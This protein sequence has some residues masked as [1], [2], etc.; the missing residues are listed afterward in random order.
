MTVYEAKALFEKASDNAINYKDSTEVISIS[1]SF[2]IIKQIYDDFEAKDKFKKCNNCKHKDGE[3][4]GLTHCSYFEQFMPTE[5]G[6]CDI[7]E[8]KSAR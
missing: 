1:S 2:I 7:W 6:K 8:D 4:G 5:I 3:S